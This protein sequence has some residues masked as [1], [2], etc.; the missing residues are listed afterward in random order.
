MRTLKGVLLGGFAALAMAS[1]TALA[2]DKAT[3]L[4]EMTIRLPGGAIEYIQ[5]TGDVA[6][7][8][9]V[10]SDPFEETWPNAAIFWSTPSFAALD[11]L[12]AEMN[13]QMDVLFRQTQALALT[14]LPN[15]GRVT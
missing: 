12:S 7:R 4:H 15:S 10:R 9:V 3:S 8:V 1:S 11:R 2:A 14:P 5:Y 13:R 6:P